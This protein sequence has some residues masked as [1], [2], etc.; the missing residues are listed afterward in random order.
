MLRI[1]DEAKA[2]EFYRD[3]LGF[4]VDWQHPLSEVG[5]PLYMQ[6]S[7]GNVSAPFVRAPR[8]CF[9]RSGTPHRDREARRF[10]HDKFEGKL[11]TNTPVPGDSRQ[12]PWGTWETTVA[13]PSIG[14][15]A[16]CFP[17]NSDCYDCAHTSGP[18]DNDAPSRSCLRPAN[19]LSTSGC[20]HISSRRA[21]AI[22]GLPF[23]S[24]NCLHQNLHILIRTPAHLDS[25]YRADPTQLVDESKAK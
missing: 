11:M 8:G 25:Q 1:F 22:A 9:A 7:S 20:L 18:G 13:E 10:L 5:S 2:R 15:Q 3:F 17:S 24:A 4:V 6:V 21:S 19:D 23:A 12:K 16:D 14:N